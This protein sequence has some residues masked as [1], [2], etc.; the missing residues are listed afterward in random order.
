MFVAEPAEIDV[1]LALIMGPT[2]MMVV[3]GQATKSTAT[4]LADVIAATGLNLK[5]VFLT[6]PHLDHSQGA[7]VLLERLPEA[8]FMATPEVARLQRARLVTEPCTKALQ[9]QKLPTKWK[10]AALL[11]SGS[12]MYPP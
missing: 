3:S 2:E 5:Y 11:P 7:S 8:S 10:N 12:R 4:R 9:F 6:H 1:T